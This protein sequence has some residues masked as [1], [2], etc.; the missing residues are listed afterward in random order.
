VFRDIHD[1]E[2]MERC[3]KQARMGKALN[4]LDKRTFLTDGYFQSIKTG[5]ITSNLKHKTLRIFRHKYLVF[6]FDN[7]S[8]DL[9]YWISITLKFSTKS[10]SFVQIL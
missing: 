8:I 9:V 6:F 1:D 2:R 5:Q 7:D 4:T 10:S 3:G